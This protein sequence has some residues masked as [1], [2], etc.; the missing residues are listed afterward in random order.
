VSQTLVPAASIHTIGHSTHPLETYLSLLRR[1]G[2]ARVVDVRRF[3]GSRR[4]PHFAR[5]ALRA[6]LAAH[7]VDYIHLEALGGRRRPVPGS[8]NAAWRVE[9]FRGYADHMASAEF[10]AALERLEALARDAPTACMCAEAD[11]E[12]CH[13]RLLADALA[14]RGWKVGHIGPHGE[15]RP[16]A[17]TPW[18][19]I[20][21]G[22]VTYP[23]RQAM[24]GVD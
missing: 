8:T 13:R 3:P 22:R 5:D 9:G 17:L 19:F 18:A 10:A 20:E 1:H 2:I 7:D 24:P 4:H 11:V 23:A 14:A 15:A 12:R 16:H 21:R 6:G